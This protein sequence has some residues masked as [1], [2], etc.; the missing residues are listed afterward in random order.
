MTDPLPPEVLNALV[1]KEQSWVKTNRVPLI[2]GAAAM[3]GI[4]LLV[5]GVVHLL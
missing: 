5:I 3:L 1:T 4:V 2:L